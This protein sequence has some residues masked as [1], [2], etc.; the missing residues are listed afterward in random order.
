MTHI[1]ERWIYR[2]K[3]IQTA[4]KF[5]FDSLVVD[6]ACMQFNDSYSKNVR[7][8]LNQK[9]NFPFVNRMAECTRI[10]NSMVMMEYEAIGKYFH[11]V[12]YR[13]TIETKSVD[14]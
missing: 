3:E 5:G 11:P 1:E 13:Q 4:E 7:P 2:S 14:N 8:L 10:Y 9:C 6:D 12:R